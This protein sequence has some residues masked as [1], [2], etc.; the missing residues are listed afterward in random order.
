[1]WYPGAG[2]E[3][4]EL[5]AGGNLKPVWSPVN[6]DWTG[7]EAQGEEFLRRATRT[8]TVWLPYGALPAGAGTAY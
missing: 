6:R 2:L 3:A 7:A 8:K 4:V 5:A 1:M